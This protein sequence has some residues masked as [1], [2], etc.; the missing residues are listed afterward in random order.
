MIRQGENMFKRLLI[1]IL[2]LFALVYSVIGNPF[3]TEPRFKLT[4]TG[5]IS[6]GG[7]CIGYMETNISFV[8]VNGS[9]KVEILYPN[10]FLRDPD[11]IGVDSLQMVISPDQYSDF[12]SDLLYLDR[13][14]ETN[15]QMSTR[16][17][18]MEIFLPNEDSTITMRREEF[19]IDYR[20]DDYLDLMTQYAV[21]WLQ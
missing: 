19:S 5:S 8:P 2:L 13:H 18:V 3:N 15:D 16:A 17:A 11:F 12:V 9:V 10:N 4:D 6:I 7:G 21:E 14:P 20:I 1:R